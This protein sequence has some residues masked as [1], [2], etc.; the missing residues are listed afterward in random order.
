MSSAVARAVEAAAP[1]P[2]VWIRPARG[3][4]LANLGELWRYRELIYF[5]IWRDVKV[6]Y[7]QTLLGAA[8]AILKPFLSMV[9]FTVIFAG[10]ARLATDGVAPPVFY[11]SGL[12]PWVLFQDGVTK[13]GN[14][15]VASSNLI[16]KVYF[17]RM[18]IPLALVVSGIVDFAL[19]FLVL[20][21]MVAYYGIHLTPA[22]WLIPLFLALALLASLGVGFWLAAL[23]VAYRDVG[24]LTPF[25]V[26]AWMYASP[27]VYSTT[28][29]PEGLGRVLFGLNPMA[30]VVQGFRWAIVGAGAP[31]IGLL[32]ASLVV[33][34]LLLVSGAL[35][36][37]RMERYFADIV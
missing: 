18:A 10:L 16:T 14:S 1:E 15:L 31:P 2:I 26:Q 33:G 17:P 29:I 4:S 13:A 22:A 30:G 8:W 7:K 28:L 11:F 3:W 5:L 37:R 27:V 12:L 25:L 32:V 21:A 35:V 24:Y 9:V 34:V 19:S 36:F 6:R 23:N 20:L